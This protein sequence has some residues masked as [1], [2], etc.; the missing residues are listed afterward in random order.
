MSKIICDVCGTS[1]PET[2]TQCP[3]CGCVRAADAHVVAGDT[4]DV[5]PHQESTYT[6]VKGGRFSKVN[7]KKRNSAQNTSAAPAESMNIESNDP[8]SVTGLII[9]LIALVLAIAAV[10]VFI[11]LRF[12]GPGNTGFLGDSTTE[13][14]TVESTQ[15]KISCISLSVEK[16]EVVFDSVDTASYKIV[17]T[18]LPANT[19]DQLLFT[20]KDD[21]V[22]T[23]SAD[24]VITPAGNGETSVRVS[25]GEIYEEIR[26]ICGPVEDTTAP[27]VESTN[28]SEEIIE[29]TV[30]TTEPSREP[31][32]P[33]VE[34]TEPSDE[35]STPT[36]LPQYTTED[37]KFKKTD[38]TM[39]EKGQVFTLYKGKIPADMITWSTDNEKI[40]VIDGG[41][42]TA[43]GKGTTNVY[44]EYADMKLTCIVRCAPT[45]GTYTE[46][47]VP[48]GTHLNKTDVT[49]QLS[50]SKSFT[51][52][53][54]TKE[55]SVIECEWEIGNDKICSVENNLVEGLAVGM[56]TVSTVYE[57][58]TYKCIVRVA[59]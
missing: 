43:V 22:A 50:G 39:G 27:S 19:T 46:S 52:N 15:Q 36:T 18:I 11:F 9:V 37:F 17:A 6:Y 16:S 47:A 44:A 40:A 24:G 3:I 56:T 35:P 58:V 55:G 45:V 25:C 10:S 2:A 8:K 41:V 4:N 51:L 34:T 13:S 32:E 38:I 49:L 21:T 30:E 59:E 23:V 53:L 31:T 20:S 14:S 57:D 28:P 29:P 7:V 42:V 33:S 48:T 26:V 1:Y 54:L 12:F 5:Q